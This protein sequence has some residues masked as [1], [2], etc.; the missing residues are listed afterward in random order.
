[1]KMKSPLR[2][3]GLLIAVFSLFSCQPATSTS[4]NTNNEE[5]KQT[6]NKENNMNNLRNAVTETLEE[7]AKKARSMN[8]QG[9]AVASVL[10]KDSEVDWIGEMKVVNTPYNAEGGDKGWN[11]VAIAWSKAGEVIASGADSG[12]PD[13]KCM[14]GELNYTGGAYGESENYK[15]AFA[16]SGGLSE[17]DLEVAKFGISYLKAKLGE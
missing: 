1:M 3:F 9:V 11:L 13:R 12:D 15:F 14:T 7:M 5:S 17:D 4:D 6:I 2:S 16:F 8:M 10:P